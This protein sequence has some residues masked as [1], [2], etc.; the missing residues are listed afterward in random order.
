MTSQ[1]AQVAGAGVTGFGDF[2]LE[3]MEGY[4]ALHLA[5][6]AQIVLNGVTASALTADDFIFPT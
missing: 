3:Q 5:N 2:L 4:T 1:A 6:G